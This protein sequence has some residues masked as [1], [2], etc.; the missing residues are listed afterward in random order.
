MLDNF[1]MAANIATI[2]ACI[3]AIVALILGTYQFIVSQK[4]SRESQ[5]VD[6]FLKFNQLNIEQGITSSAE[7]DHWYNNGKFAITESLYN[8]AP[9]TN[10]WSSTLKWMLDQQE[11][12]IR[13][14]NFDVNTYS[15]DFRKFCKNHG[16]ELKL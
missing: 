10:S 12:F 1:S 9:K 8:I 3:V 13:R 16:L 11:D 5:S 2:V 15:D 7:S 6:L 4:S 14:G